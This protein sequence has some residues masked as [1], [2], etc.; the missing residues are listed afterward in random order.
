MDMCME[1]CTD[2]CIDMHVDMCMEM[3]TDMCIDM[4]IDMC[5]EMRIDMCTDMCIDMCVDMYA[6]HSLPT[7]FHRPQSPV[8]SYSTLLLLLL[9][10]VTALIEAYNRSGAYIHLLRLLRQ[11]LAHELE[12]VQRLCAYGECTP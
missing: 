1:M 6:S 12:R 10:F 2:M 7:A 11:D 9:D 5:T 3:C 8:I 4:C